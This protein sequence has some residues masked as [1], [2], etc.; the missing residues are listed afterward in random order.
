LLG[1]SDSITEYG[2]PHYSSDI[3]SEKVKPTKIEKQ[4]TFYFKKMIP[5]LK[6]ESNE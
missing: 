4:F 6:K 5:T 1:G 2:T 3:Y